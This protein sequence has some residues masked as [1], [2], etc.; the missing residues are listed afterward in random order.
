MVAHTCNHTY[1]GGSDCNDHSSRTVQV[2]SSQVPISRIIRPKCTTSMAQLVEHLLCNHKVLSSSRVQSPPPKKSIV[3][4]INLLCKSIYFKVLV[5]N[6]FI[7][8]Q[9]HFFVILSFELGAL[10]LVCKVLYHLSFVPNPFCF[11]SFSERVLYVCP[12]PAS[13]H[14]LSLY[15]SSVAGITDLYHHPWL[16]NLSLKIIFSM[17]A[18]NNSGSCSIMF[19]QRIRNHLTFKRNMYAGPASF[20]FLISGKALL[21]LK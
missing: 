20:T 14:D 1:L 16:G 7:E 3:R 17:P 15:V 2:N 5:I 13:N 10:Y 6:L 11:S 19:K 4:S 9:S 12:G 8:I 21:R 18:A